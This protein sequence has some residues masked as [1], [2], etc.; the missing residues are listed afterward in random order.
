MN[1]FSLIY[2]MASFQTK[3]M[4]SKRFVRIPF[5]A[6][7]SRQD[8]SPDTA[9][10]SSPGAVI[11]VHPVRLEA[12]R[13]GEAQLGRRHAQEVRIGASEALGGH[14]RE[15]READDGHD[16][17]VVAGGGR[18]DAR[19]PCG[20]GFGAIGGLGG[21]AAGFV[22]CFYWGGGSRAGAGERQ[23]IYGKKQ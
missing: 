9:K 5:S 10:G 2:N 18:Q 17:V 8:P 20:E 16:Q 12:E 1:D 19:P 6:H 15:G 21:R 13:K 7:F 23:Q 14:D 4:P 11:K 3:V 22:D